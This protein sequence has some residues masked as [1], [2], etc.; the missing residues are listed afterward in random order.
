MKPVLKAPGTM[1][2]KLR[3]DGPLSNFGFNFDLRRYTMEAMEVHSV[4]VMHRF[5]SRCSEARG[6]FRTNTRPTLNL[7]PLFRGVYENKHSTDVEFPPPLPRASVR[8][9][10]IKVSRAPISVECLF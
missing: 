3:Y 7:V 2:L 4:G 9:V 1:L 10:T 5:L 8:A 6:V